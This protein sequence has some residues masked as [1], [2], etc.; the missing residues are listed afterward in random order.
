MTR[1]ETGG[2]GRLA[3]RKAL[4]SL[5]LVGFL[6][7]P[8]RA[9][10]ADD[11]DGGV[12]SVDAGV[13]EEASDAGVAE[14]VVAEAPEE[15]LP[16]S[17]VDP[18]LA[19]EEPAPP[20]ATEVIKIIF[21]LVV[22]VALAYLG[23]HPTVRALEERLRISHVVAAGFPFVLLGLVARLPSVGIVSDSVLDEIRPILPFGLGW[24]GLALGFRFDVRDLDR[25]PPRLELAFGLLTI[26]PFALTFAAC[27]AL[28]LLVGDSEGPVYLSHALI[29]AT[30]SMIS[31]SSTPV[32]VHATEDGAGVD[33]LTRI[34][35]LEQ[36]AVVAGLAVIGAF[37][38]PT[39]ALVGWQLPAM[40]WLIVTI[41]LGGMLGMTT[42]AVLAVAR[43][44]IEVM[45]V[46]L[47]SICFS[48][49]LASFL[50]LS[51]TVVC[52]AAGLLL[53]TVPGAYKAQVRDTLTRLEAPIYFLF[54]FLAGAHW[55]LDD[56]EGWALLVAFVAARAIG[57]QLGAAVLSSRSEGD[58]SAEQRRALALSPMGALA[59]ATAVSAQ[60]LY[61]GAESSWVVTA[62]IGGAILNEVLVQALGRTGR[63]PL[64]NVEE[65]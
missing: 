4:R 9:A 52:F 34:V 50:R 30:A 2:R 43:S 60:D 1:D 61:A 23:G 27:S 54:L 5:L 59:I 26:P 58:L 44:R 29:L 46:L 3:A 32:I 40:A 64:P 36:F 41:G 14:A 37:F 49:G 39:G 47:G 38:R 6:S 35:Q 22:I 12:R 16:P 28:F 21:G 63:A 57:K 31:A 53:A 24:I 51:P 8:L 18:P 42:Y 13:S 25:P 48:A 45:V 17:S 7:V 56:L 15:P 55:R 65:R 10:Y 20:T 19:P 33:R 11:L 62:V